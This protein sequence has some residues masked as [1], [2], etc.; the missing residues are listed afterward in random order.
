MSAALHFISAALGAF[1]ALGTACAVW[2]GAARQPA[3]A[4]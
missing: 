2:L 1:T 4:L 3:R